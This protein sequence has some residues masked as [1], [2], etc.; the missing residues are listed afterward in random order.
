ML[1]TLV[2]TIIE[3]NFATELLRV[4]RMSFGHSSS[5]VYEPT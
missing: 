1:H 4:T 3:R 2:D 5:E